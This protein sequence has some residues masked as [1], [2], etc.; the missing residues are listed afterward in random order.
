CAG[1]QVRQTRARRGTR[2]QPAR[3]R[4]ISR[5]G[6]RADDRRAQYPDRHSAR[7]RV[8]RRPEAASPLLSRRSAGRGRSCG[9]PRDAG[10]AGAGGEE[11]G[12]RSVAGG[13]VAEKRPARDHSPTFRLSPD[14]IYSTGSV[15]SSAAI[16]SERR[17]RRSLAVT[18]NVRRGC[19]TRAGAVT[20]VSADDCGRLTKPT[21]AS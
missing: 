21:T 1:D 12:L 20:F 16:R 10:G 14:S 13:G 6:R 9:A 3:A 17:K 19:T 4:E 7:L 11:V 5:P 18:S 2:Q 15:V 8:E